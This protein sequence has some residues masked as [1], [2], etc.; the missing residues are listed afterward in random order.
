MT[1]LT[2]PDICGKLETPDEYSKARSVRW[3]RQWIDPMYTRHIGADNRKHVFLS[4][5]DCYALRCSF[6][7]GRDFEDRGAKSKESIRR[8]SFYHPFAGYEYSLQPIR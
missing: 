2:L 1:A 4:A 7:H 5:E 3:L 6:L 8:L